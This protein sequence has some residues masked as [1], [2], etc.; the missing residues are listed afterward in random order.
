MQVD[1]EDRYAPEQDS[2]GLPKLP[3][4]LAV[5]A[6]VIGIAWYFSGSSPEPEPPAAELITPVPAE[7]PPPLAPPPAP[8]PDIPAPT[9][10]GTDTSDPNDTVIE[11]EPEPELT[12]EDSDPVVRETLAPAL[13]NSVFAQALRQ[14]DLLERGTAFIDAAGKGS[15]L[16]K[17]F[18]LPPPE[19]KFEVREEAGRVVM[20]PATYARYDDYA[21][22]IGA[23]DP[24][25]LA[26][27]FHRFRPLL[28]QAY[29]NLGYPQEDM[30]NSLIRALDQVIAAPVLDEPPA[31]KQHV[32]TYTYA[33][34]SLEELPPIAKQL[35]RM[36]PDNQRIIQDQARALRAALLAE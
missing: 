7:S 16:N 11:P 31:L 20:D 5:L 19:G 32:T 22:A 8:A 6:L 23:L 18:T 36:G 24:E 17:V 33:D 10:I 14:D 35:L 21:E 15:L 3:I 34:E 9:T 25:T 28:E 13:D 30:D 27:A 1:S 4:A 2:P 12:L 26:A 29:G